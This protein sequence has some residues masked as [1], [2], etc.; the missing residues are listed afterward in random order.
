[1]KRKS[2][3]SEPLWRKSAT[4]EPEAVALLALESITADPER[5]G[6]FLSVTGLDA[7]S[8]RQAAADPA[9]L[10]SVLDYV[11]GDEELLVAIARETGLAPE[12]IGAAQAR[13]SPEP[14]WQA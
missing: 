14:D 4:Q 3:L 2:S 8:I 6:R 1:M 13:L 9:F 5:L 7:G 10:P 11:A 12:E